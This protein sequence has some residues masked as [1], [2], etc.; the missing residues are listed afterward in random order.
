MLDDA[1]LVDQEEAAE[2]DAVV[3]EQDAVVTGD[4]LGEVGD[5]G[6]GEALDAALFALGVGPGEVREVRVGRDADH[7]GIPLAELFDGVREREDLGG[8][9]EGEVEGVEEQDDV[10]A[11]VVGQGDLLELAVDDGVGLELGSSHLR[12]EHDFLLNAGCGQR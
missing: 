1:V 9:N 11:L 2:G 12:L 7:F 3:L 5:E 8:A 6:V 4:L 10:L